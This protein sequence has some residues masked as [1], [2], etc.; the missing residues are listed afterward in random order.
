MAHLTF[1]PC[2]GDFVVQVVGDAGDE[3]EIA[4]GSVRKCTPE[5]K[6]VFAQGNRGDVGTHFEGVAQVTA[7]TNRVFEGQRVAEEV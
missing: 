4:G 1:L 6:K 7:V 3:G 5:V 2:D